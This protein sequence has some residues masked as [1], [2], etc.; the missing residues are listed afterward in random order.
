MRS[1]G[2]GDHKSV[3]NFSCL[4]LTLKLLL[5]EKAGFISPLLEIGWPWNLLW[6]QKAVEVI[7]CW[8]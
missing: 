7:V 3:F 8:F 2:R 6:L 4:Q 1:W 5:S